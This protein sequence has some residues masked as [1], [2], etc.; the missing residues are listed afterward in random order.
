MCAHVV[1]DERKCSFLSSSRVIRG[2]K[3]KKESSLL[4]LEKVTDTRPHDHCQPEIVADLGNEE[5]A[6]DDAA[7]SD[8]AGD[9]VAGDEAAGSKT[10]GSK[11]AGSETAGSEAAVED[12]AVEPGGEEE[13]RRSEQERGEPNSYDDRVTKATDL[14]SCVTCNRMQR[15]WFRDWCAEFTYDKQVKH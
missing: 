4:A 14:E 1:K 8:A 11:T 3:V 12:R 13:Q 2:Q 10:A 15:R 7:G 6:E 9:A 5:R